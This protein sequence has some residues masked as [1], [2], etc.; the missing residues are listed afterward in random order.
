MLCFASFRGGDV[1]CPCRAHEG[2]SSVCISRFLLTG[3]K[4]QR[5]DS[6]LPQLPAGLPVPRQPRTCCPQRSK[7]TSVTFLELRQHF[8]E[9]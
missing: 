2:L 1:S 9:T 8:Q 7:E 4:R 6:P 5:L 3:K